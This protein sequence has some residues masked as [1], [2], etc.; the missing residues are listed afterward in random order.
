MKDIRPWM[1]DDF[2]SKLDALRAEEPKLQV[3]LGMQRSCEHDLVVKVATDAEVATYVEIGSGHPTLLHRV[4]EALPQARVI[5]FEISKLPP[6]VLKGCKAAGIEQ[7]IQDV[8]GDGGKRLGEQVK[9]F[10]EE[11]EGPVFVYTDNGS[12]HKE[13]HIVTEHMRVGDICGSHDFSGPD[14]AVGLRF[15]QGRQF[16]TLRQ[17]EHYILDHLCL[18][19]FWQ[20]Q[21]GAVKEGPCD[22]LV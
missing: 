20:K 9:G 22:H 5:G 21:S 16:A 1:P 2:N 13:M 3:N 10:I 19:R 4:K 18:Q 12:K 7:Y 15:M 14:W 11:S 17:Y 8:L 6:K